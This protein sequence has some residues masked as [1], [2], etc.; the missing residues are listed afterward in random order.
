MKI[1]KNSR[2]YKIL[3]YMHTFINKPIPENVCQLFWFVAEGTFKLACAAGVIITIAAIALATSIFA[4]LAFI[5]AVFNFGIMR[6]SIDVFVLSAII[7]VAIGS[8]SIAIYRQTDHY[9]NTLEK[10]REKTS[11]ALHERND[12]FIALVSQYSRSIKD[13]VC[14]TVEYY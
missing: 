9:T 14:P 1:S 11:K 3:K 13:K 8:L 12:G 10:R 4:V 5:E 2:F 6:L 7:W